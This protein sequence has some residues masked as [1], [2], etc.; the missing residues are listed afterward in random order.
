MHFWLPLNLFGVLRCSLSKL[1]A[2][3][4]SLGLSPSEG[5]LAGSL[6]RACSAFLNAMLKSL[7]YVKLVPAFRTLYGY[8]VVYHVL[9]LSLFIFVTCFAKCCCAEGLFRIP[10]QRARE[11]APELLGLEGGKSYRV[12]AIP[13]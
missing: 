7:A 3:G 6:P 5:P 8:V 10:A 9:L 1:R 11:L 4:H 13:P 2:R 12:E